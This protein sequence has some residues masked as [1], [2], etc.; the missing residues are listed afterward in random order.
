[1][2]IEIR[3]PELVAL[4]QEHMESGAFQT[5]DELL[6][7]ALKSSRSNLPVEDLHRRRLFEWME[8]A[9]P[10]WNP[11]LHPELAEGAAHWVDGLRR[12]D[13]EIDSTTSSR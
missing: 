9:G 10:G 12:N 8:Q 5:V 3:Q 2:T 4:I 7:Q 13:E 6:I 1:M 11:E